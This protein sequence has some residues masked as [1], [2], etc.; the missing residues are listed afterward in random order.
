MGCHPNIALDRFPKQGTWLG[1]RFDVCF[2]YDA[3][4]TIG[5]MCVREDAEEPGRMILQLDDGRFVLAT[6]CQ[7]SGPLSAAPSR[8]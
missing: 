2:N 1:R 5:A 4:K 7:H 3:S 8:N 6:E